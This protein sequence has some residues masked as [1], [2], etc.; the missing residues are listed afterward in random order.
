MSR[1]RKVDP[2]DSYLASIKGYIQ[3]LPKENSDEIVDEIRVHLQS[4]I[5]ALVELG[6]DPAVAPDEAIRRF[7]PAPRIGRKIVEDY[8]Y[9]WAWQRDKYGLATTPEIPQWLF[10][11]LMLAASF[12]AV[13]YGPNQTILVLFVIYGAISETTDIIREGFKADPDTIA[14]RSI[15]V[16]RSLR[17]SNVPSILRRTR[18]ARLIVYFRLLLEQ[19]VPSLISGQIRLW[20][21][22]AACAFLA[23]AYIRGP[24]AS[25]EARIVAGA[26]IGALFSR[27]VIRH[28][29][30][31]LA[32]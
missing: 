26:A 27:L 8:P 16:A 2:V 13:K 30:M 11:I 19:R 9:S 6:W 17:S 14:F 28:L 1:A 24:V 4:S 7:G 20:T 3:D 10:S 23:A 15:S 21:V 22:L 32:S 25:F 29:A 5:D 31:R 18:I 12:A